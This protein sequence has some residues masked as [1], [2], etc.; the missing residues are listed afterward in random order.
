MLPF[1]NMSGDPA[2]DYF[3]DGLSEELINALSR[4]PQL[5]VA[6]RISSFSFKGKA[7]TV[8]DIG[9]GLNVATILEG[10]VRR[11]ESQLRITAQ[12]AGCAQRFPDLVAQ[13]RSQPA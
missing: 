8:T 10:S 12:L 1:T 6:A 7:A 3:S 2:Q 13:L 4:T 5:R 9:R 11:G